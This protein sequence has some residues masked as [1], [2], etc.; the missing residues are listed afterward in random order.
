MQ[1]NR[2]GKYYFLRFRRLKGDPYALAFGTAM[3]LVGLTN[4]AAYGHHPRPTTY[5]T[6]AVAAILSSLIVSNPLTFVPI[7][8]FSTLI[9]NAL[10]PYELNWEKIQVVVDQLSSSLGIAHTF[11]ILA[12]LGLRP[13]SCSSEALSWPC[14]ASLASYYLPCT[15]SLKISQTPGQAHTE[16][17]RTSRYSSFHLH[18]NHLCQHT[19]RPGSAAAAWSPKKEI[20]PEFSVHRHTAEAIVRAGQV[21]LEDIVE[22]GVG[23]AALTLPLAQSVRHVYGI[24]IDS[25]IVRLHEQEQDLPDNVTLIHQDILK[26]DFSELAARCGGR[27][28]IIA[29]LP[30]S[31]SNPFIF[32][33]IDNRRHVE[34]ATIMLQRS[35]PTTGRSP[36]FQRLRYPI[37]PA[38]ELCSVKKLMTLSPAEFHP[39]PK[40]DSMVIR[41]QFN[42]PAQEPRAH[43]Q[44]MKTSSRG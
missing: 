34:Q 30:Y 17:S 44:A 29:N 14:F 9:G 13:Q 8:Y 11:E 18:R 20:R 3:R 4:H 23:L 1:F 41:I 25:G 6:S 28:K 35:V 39:Q 2:L 33:L 22:V 21:G 26:A 27:L 15:L 40:I 12:G 42:L 38:A 16:L 36:R 37:S 10:T 7:Y 32:K 43:R 19:E 24:E 31:I 5:R